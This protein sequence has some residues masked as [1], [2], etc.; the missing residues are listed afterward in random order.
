[1]IKE[2]VNV[3][4]RAD[5]LPKG[6]TF[7]IKEGEKCILYYV[8]EKHEIYERTIPQKN[9][10][11]ADLY[12]DILKTVP[13]F[14]NRNGNIIKI[15][16]PKYEEYEDIEVPVY[17]INDDYKI[18]Y[19]CT[20]YFAHVPTIRMVQKAFEYYE[21]I[22][23]DMQKSVLLAK[24]EDGLK[25]N[26]DGISTI[27]ETYY[28]ITEYID[29]EEFCIFCIKKPYKN[30]IDYQT[31]VIDKKAALNKSKNGVI[32]LCVPKEMVDFVSGKGDMCSRTMIAHELG[33][34]NVFI[35][36]C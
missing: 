12:E 8:D 29:S 31:L 14:Y 17:C 1:M 33:V 5:A 34:K 25:Y 7:A 30:R 20:N 13:V 23:K 19:M 15:F 10:V 18:V 26:K 24:I 35:K 36:A 27:V 21:K 11:I 28:D 2:V 3:I 6:F 32:R 9:T 22:S 16:D 4:E